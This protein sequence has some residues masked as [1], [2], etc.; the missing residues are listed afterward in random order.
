M[1]MQ[2]QVK[3]CETFIYNRLQK[4]FSTGGEV[5]NVAKYLRRVRKICERH[6]VQRST[7]VEVALA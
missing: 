4:R 1:L 7:P 5:L 6:D 2:K 3:L